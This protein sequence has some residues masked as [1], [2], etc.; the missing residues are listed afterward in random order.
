M[1]IYDCVFFSMKRNIWF[2]KYYKYLK[3]DKLDIATRLRIYEKTLSHL[4]LHRDQHI[5]QKQSFT[6]IKEN[7]V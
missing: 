3:L 1:Y 4:F 6:M 5:S 2:V 7:G